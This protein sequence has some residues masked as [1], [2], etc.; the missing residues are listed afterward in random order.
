VFNLWRIA[1][2]E[3]VAEAKRRGAG[4]MAANGRDVGREDL[5]APLR[6][7]RGFQ[8]QSC[9][10]SS[11]QHPSSVIGVSVTALDRAPDVL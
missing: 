4:K 11:V 8:D 5:V 2:V 1:L 3:Q 9:M 6:W 7:T 10:L